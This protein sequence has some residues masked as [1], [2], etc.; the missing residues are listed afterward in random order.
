[1]ISFSLLK[2]PLLHRSQIWGQVM[3][4][5]SSC[6][7]SARLKC[8][9]YQLNEAPEPRALLAECLIWKTKIKAP[10]DSFTMPSSAAYHLL[11]C[12]KWSYK[13]TVTRKGSLSPVPG[14][15][16]DC[17]RMLR[18]WLRTAL[19]EFWFPSQHQHSMSLTL[20][21]RQKVLYT[22]C[23]RQKASPKEMSPPR[24]SI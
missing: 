16:N 17:L 4:S 9:R 8:T 11:T 12:C 3:T 5:C 6:Y 7:P 15:L 18:R 1:M 20:C 13:G 14:N 24:I 10:H 2:N 21:N 22:V 23:Y 19:K